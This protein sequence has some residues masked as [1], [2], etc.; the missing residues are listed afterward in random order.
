LEEE[1]MD[2]HIFKFVE[3][4]LYKYTSNKKL[5][6][7]VDAEVSTMPEA[8]ASALGNT[9]GGHSGKTSNTTMSKAMRMVYM[10]KK[11]ERARFYTKAIEDTM[12]LLDPQGQKL[13]ELKYFN[14]YYTNAGVMR[15]LHITKNVFYRLR[16]E[17]IHR[18]AE[19]MGVV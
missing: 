1:R 15:E 5:I 19:R 10:Q 7:S 14:Q 9:S 2:V 4:E 17:V 12:E 13:I 3:K 6:E 11:A 18:I 8:I 16:N